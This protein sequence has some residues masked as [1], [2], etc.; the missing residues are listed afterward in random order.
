MISGVLTL[1]KTLVEIILFRK[2]PDEIPNSSLLF[3][4]VATIWFLVGVIAVMVVESYKSPDLFVDLILAIVG[5]VFYAIVVNSFGRSARLVQCFTAL[6]GCSVVFSIVLFAGRTILPML[7]TEDETGW[8]VQL[9]WLWSIP[10]EGH[11]IARTIDRQW[12]IGFLIAL[13]VLF[14]QLQLFAALKPILGPT[15]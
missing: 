14:A 9:I 7:I 15:A 4:V 8:A 6:L 13:A 1:F 5:L 2:G 12:I 11:I 10:V 3:I